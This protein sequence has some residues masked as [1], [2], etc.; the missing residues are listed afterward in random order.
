MRGIRRLALLVSLVSGAS[1]MF[2]DQAQ[3]RA[4]G[5][6]W[7]IEMCPSV[8]ELRAECQRLCGASSTGGLC[9]QN[10]ECPYDHYVIMCAGGGAEE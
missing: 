6:S 7:C 8:S 5:C 2:P 3:A 10:D 1:L 9:G 4:A